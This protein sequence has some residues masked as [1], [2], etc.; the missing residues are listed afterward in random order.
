MQR[1]RRAHAPGAYLVIC[2][3]HPG[4]C[5]RSTLS[6]GLWWWHSPRPVQRHRRALAPGFHL[7]G[8]ETYFSD[9]PSFR[10]S[11]VGSHFIVAFRSCREGLE[12]DWVGMLILAETTYLKPTKSSGDCVGISDAFGSE[13]QICLCI[14]LQEGIELDWVGKLILAEA[15]VKAW[16]ATGDGHLLRQVRSHVARYR[17]GIKQYK[18]IHSSAAQH[19]TRLVTSAC[20]WCGPATLCGGETTS[21]NA[22]QVAPQEST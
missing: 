9:E 2:P 17:K 15:T 6:A 19:G 14:M 12:L 18:H 11:L 10:H 13:V 5:H 4:I 20:C 8:P 16:H 1:H 7:P 3:V 21:K 22:G